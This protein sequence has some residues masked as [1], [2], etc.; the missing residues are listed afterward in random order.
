[1][2]TVQILVLCHNH[3]AYKLSIS[4]GIGNLCNII[5]P[6]NLENNLSY[7]YRSSGADHQELC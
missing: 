3:N 1:M 2:T 5:I 6:G 7:L 4:G